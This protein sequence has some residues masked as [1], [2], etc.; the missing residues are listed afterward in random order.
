MVWYIIKF[1]YEYYVNF[2]L[3]AIFYIIVLGYT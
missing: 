1:I 2:A 3:Q